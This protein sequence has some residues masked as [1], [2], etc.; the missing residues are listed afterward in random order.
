MGLTVGGSAYNVLAAAAS[1]V[2]GSCFWKSL[3][4]WISSRERFGVGL[5]GCAVGMLA[6]GLSAVPGS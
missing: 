5:N 3:A 4:S 2:E 6:F 1:A